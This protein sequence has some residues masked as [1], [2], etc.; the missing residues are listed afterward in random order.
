MT[1]KGGSFIL[2]ELCR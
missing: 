2:N 1:T